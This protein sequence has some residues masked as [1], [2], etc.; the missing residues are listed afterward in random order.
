MAVPLFRRN[1]PSPETAAR[2]FFAILP[3]KDRLE[4][5]ALQGRLYRLSYT[6]KIRH[7]R[8]GLFIRVILPE[9]F[10]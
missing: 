5:P 10:V 8:A 7:Q 2:E 4:L 1:A 3:Q 9:R 6:G